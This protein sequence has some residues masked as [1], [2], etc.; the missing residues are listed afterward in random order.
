MNTFA[1]IMAC[2]IVLCIVSLIVAGTAWCLS[3]V[4]RSIGKGR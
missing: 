3:K 2:I 1:L 4:I